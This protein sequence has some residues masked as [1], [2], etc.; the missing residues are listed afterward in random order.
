MFVRSKILTAFTKLQAIHSGNRSEKMVY[1]NFSHLIVLKL[2]FS[3]YKYYFLFDSFLIRVSTTIDI[4]WFSSYLQ[5][6]AESKLEPL[7][8]TSFSISLLIHKLF[9]FIDIKTLGRA[10]REN[11][12]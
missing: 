8:S 12:K 6:N 9:S 2:L 11:E 1:W 10:V 5:T 4:V 7:S 3:N